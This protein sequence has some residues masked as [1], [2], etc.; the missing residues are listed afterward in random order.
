MYI[1][2]IRERRGINRRALDV[3]NMMT[4]AELKAERERQRA[5]EPRA[6]RAGEIAI[7]PTWYDGE[8][9]SGWQVYGAAGELLE[10]LGIAHY[11]SGWGY[12][13]NNGVIEKLGQNFTYPQA[14][15]Y[16]Q[17]AIEAKAA[18]ERARSEERDGK[19]AEAKRIGQPILLRRAT[20]ECDD[21]REECDLDIVCE[22][23]M[24]DGT[25]KVV[26]KHTW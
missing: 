3:R 24:P 6:I 2:Y 26:R 19:F 20:V 11:V 12:E 22:Y 18:A 23:A 14:V 9:V 13:I 21:P 16:A 15:E 1:L 7:V 4:R 8:I 5:D 10:K 17:P 25:K